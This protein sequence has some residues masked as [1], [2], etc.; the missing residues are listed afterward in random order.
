MAARSATPRPRC[1]GTTPADRDTEDA[2]HAAGATP[3]APPEPGAFG[4]ALGPP[5]GADDGPAAWQR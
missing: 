3:I 5:I 2:A 4:V 1:G